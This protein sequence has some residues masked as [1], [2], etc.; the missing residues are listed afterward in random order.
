MEEQREMTPLQRLHS[1]VEET[2][3]AYDQ[4]ERELQ[5]IALQQKQS[6]SE[7]ERLAQ[8]NAQIASRVRQIE[9]NLESYPREDI[10]ETYT[11][12]QDSQMRL[13]TMRSQV[14]RLQSKREALQAEAEQLHRFLEVAQDIEEPSPTPSRESTIV[15]VIEAQENE[16]RRL[17]RQ[18][19]DGPAQSLTN[20]ILQAEICERLFDLDPKQAHVELEN[21]KQAVNATFQNTRRFIFGLRPM[22]LDDLGLV[23]TLRRYIQDFREKSRLSIDLHIMGEERQLAPHL[24]VTIFRVIQELLNN[25][26]QHAH[27]AHVDVTLDLEGE[28]VAVTVEDDGCGFDAEEVL[29]AVRE[30]KS[31]GLLTIQERTEML[32]GKVEID[33]SVGRGTKVRLELPE[34]V[35]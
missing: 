10:K 6:S 7:V 35:P 19:H 4:I 31:V 26:D 16:R 27:A 13:F 32:G 24:E 25:V 11:A 28:A 29:A 22:M 33:S 14:E 23:P 21:L 34:I 12:A 1:L 15:R 9:I 20:L 30:R 8:R 3:T 18:M 2:K 17:A 5:E